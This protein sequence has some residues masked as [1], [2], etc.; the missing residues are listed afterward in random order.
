[1]A[2]FFGKSCWIAFNSGIFYSLWRVSVRGLTTAWA[3]F[4]HALV[5]LLT[6]CGL[7][8]DLLDPPSLSPSSSPPFRAA[9]GARKENHPPL[10]R[11][12]SLS[13][14]RFVGQSHLVQENTFGKTGDQKL[15]DGLREMFSDG[16]RYIYIYVGWCFI[17]F[18]RYLRSRVGVK[19]LGGINFSPIFSFLLILLLVIFFFVLYFCPFRA[20]FLI[21]IPIYG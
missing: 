6:A 3:E 20:I 14:G 15:L 5:K 4:I 11:S 7:T 1:M 2:S 18:Q 16:G 8:I 10:L 17:G 13:R 21:L 12:T 9:R 19:F